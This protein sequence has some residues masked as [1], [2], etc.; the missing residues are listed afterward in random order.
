[1]YKISIG[2]K[3]RIITVSTQPPLKFKERD[4]P[5]TSDKK[6]GQEELKQPQRDSRRLTIESVNLRVWS[7]SLFRRRSNFSVSPRPSALPY[8]SV[9]LLVPVLL[10]LRLHPP[11]DETAGP[12]Y[13][14]ILPIRK[15]FVLF[16][17]EGGR[18]HE[19]G[20]RALCLQLYCEKERLLSEQFKHSKTLV[21]IGNILGANGTIKHTE[22]GTCFYVSHVGLFRR[23]LF[24]DEFF[25]NSY[26]VTTSLTDKYHGLTDVDKLFWYTGM[27]ANSKVWKMAKGPGIDQLVMLLTDSASIWNVIAFPVVKA[28][29]NINPF[30]KTEI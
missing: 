2:S 25:C 27:I 11:T 1:M 10:P 20:A 4:D 5:P 17:K 15:H 6:T 24:V 12:P 14:P 3:S 19:Q 28:Q 18:A 22:K 26:K 13:P 8:S 7:P 16:A 21:N 30:S 23:A 9:A 29:P